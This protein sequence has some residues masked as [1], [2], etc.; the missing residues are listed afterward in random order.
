[1]DLQQICY[2]ENL[3]QIYPKSL[4]YPQ[5]SIDLDEYE[6]EVIVYLLEVSSKTC[7]CSSR[8]AKVA[9]SQSP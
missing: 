4:F 9:V 7:L 3:C 1:M 5:I 2:V 8:G 6:I